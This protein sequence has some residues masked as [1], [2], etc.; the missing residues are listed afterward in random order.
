MTNYF[1]IL[2]DYALRMPQRINWRQS[3]DVSKICD[4]LCNKKYFPIVTHYEDPDLYELVRNLDIKWCWPSHSW[5]QGYHKKIESVLVVLNTMGIR[6]IPSLHH[7]LAYENKGLVTEMMNSLAIPSPRSY[8]VATIENLERIVSKLDYPFVSKK[9]DGFA[10]A[11]VQLLLSNRDF[12]KL[13]QKEFFQQG[14]L[15]K[16]IGEVV[17]QEYLEGLKGDWK[18]VVIGD[19]VTTLWRNV[20]PGDFRASGSGLFEFFKAPDDVLD[21]AFKVKTM[22]NSPWV[23]LDIAVTQEG[24]KLLEYQI[25]HFG[26][27]TIDYAK[28]H[29]IHHNDGTW[30][31]V[32]GGFDI[33]KA[34]VASVLSEIE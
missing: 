19:I 15:T 14:N 31:V 32:P 1:L 8:Y 17:I 11:G 3:F 16:G 18:V 25:V 4:L 33:E 34:M 10:S 9:L 23:S 30:E 27:T 21:F 28:E 12:E 20:K 5:T 6:L 29:Y 22:L 7:F 26:T 2:T 24:C 13:I